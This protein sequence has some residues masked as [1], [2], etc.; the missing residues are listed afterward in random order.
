MSIIGEKLDAINDTAK[1]ADSCFFILR[2]P[3]KIFKDY[4]IKQWNIRLL[5]D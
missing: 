4:S 3:W 1:I 2:P 5:S